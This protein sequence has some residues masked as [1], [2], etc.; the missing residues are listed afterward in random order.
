MFYIDIKTIEL[1]KKQTPFQRKM[2]ENYMNQRRE[3]SVY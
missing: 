2:I 1:V 3:V